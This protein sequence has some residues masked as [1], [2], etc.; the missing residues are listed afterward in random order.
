M[1]TMHTNQL[2]RKW[3]ETV[4]KAWD[5]EA[6]KNRLIADPAAVLKEQGLQVRP[7][8]QVRVLENT[9]KIVHLTLPPKP[10]GEISE[11]QLEHV[12]AGTVMVE[13][14][15][16]AQTITLEAVAGPSQPAT[17]TR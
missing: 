3:A 7:G 9:D 14:I 13:Y 12:A 8:I 6:F 16:V 5:N 15:A 10:S 1:T 17:T 4:T 11:E 2:K